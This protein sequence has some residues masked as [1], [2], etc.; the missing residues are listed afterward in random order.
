M[1]YYGYQTLVPCSSPPSMLIHSN[2][3]K[4]FGKAWALVHPCPSQSQPWCSRRW[5][6][7]QLPGSFRTQPRSSRCSWVV[8]TCENIYVKIIIIIILWPTWGNLSFPAACRIAALWD[9]AMWSMLDNVGWLMLVEC[10]LML[11]NVASSSM[12]LMTEVK[13]AKINLL[14]QDFLGKKKGQTNWQSRPTMSQILHR[15]LQAGLWNDWYWDL[16]HI[17]FHLLSVLSVL[18]TFHQSSRGAC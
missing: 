10:W 9:L 14:E 12:I 7:W 17:R 11:V 13:G 8:K 5:Q 16:V 3:W 18:A 6:R 15:F 1:G 2:L 4:R